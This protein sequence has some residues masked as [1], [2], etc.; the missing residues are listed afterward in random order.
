MALSFLLNSKEGEWLNKL[1]VAEAQYRSVVALVEQRNQLHL[2]FQAKL[3]ASSESARTSEGTLGDIRGI[4][5]KMLG[6]QLEDLTDELYRTTEHSIGF[7]RDVY[8]AAVSSFKRLFPKS[9]MFGVEDLPL[10]QTD[11]SVPEKPK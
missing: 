4:A 10:G 3:Q 8:V 7:N 1:G 11:D 9:P 6:R 5:G 2:A